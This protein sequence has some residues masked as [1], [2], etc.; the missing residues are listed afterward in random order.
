MLIF[1]ISAL[2]ITGVPGFNAY[3][4]KSML[5]HAI[6]EAFAHEGLVSLWWAEKI[7]TLSSALTVCYFTKLFRGLF[8][9]EIPEKYKKLPDIPILMKL[10]LTSFAAFMLFIG[11]FPHVPFKAIVLPTVS[12]FGYDSY[13]FGY[14]EKFKIFNGEDIM[15]AV[16]VFLLASI[17]YLTFEK[18]NLYKT[19]FPQWM[20]VDKLVYT[21][22]I[23]GFMFMCLGP[24]VVLDRT[25]NKMY[26]GTG[27]A[28]MGI[29][30][31]IGEIETNVNKAYSGAGKISIAVC[32][33]ID[34]FE[35]TVNELSKIGSNE[36]ICQG[37]AKLDGTTSQEYSQITESMKEAKDKG[38]ITTLKMCDMMSKQQG[39][40]KIMLDADFNCK[41]GHCPFAPDK[42]CYKK[43]PTF[44]EKLSVNPDWNLKNLNFDTLI[45]AT[46]FTILL[47]IL[48]FFSK[49][50]L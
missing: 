40:H 2:G 21:P 13:A 50:I 25:V 39:E 38:T 7:F 22:L 1:I 10:V 35:S 49:E 30:K 24:G 27:Q 42:K 34:H 43:E 37:I 14:V 29:F 17:I 4:S 47:L 33:G 19:S 32:H 6:T 36:E 46:L 26:Q 45:V 11:F 15:A 16:I 41:N 8:L 9:G 31:Q 3:P 48:V 44:W 5:H 18:F 28:S 20:S 23:K 12:T